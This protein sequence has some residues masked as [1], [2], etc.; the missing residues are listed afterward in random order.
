MEV[1][2]RMP[3]APR[4]QASSLLGVDAITGR[5]L[6]EEAA[7]APPAPPCID[8]EAASSRHVWCLGGLNQ[9]PDGGDLHT[10]FYNPATTRLAA[11]PMPDLPMPEKTQFAPQ[12]PVLMEALVL[13]GC[14]G[15]TCVCGSV[16]IAELLPAS[17][18]AL[19][20]TPR[21]IVRVR[22][23]LQRAGIV[24]A[25]PALAALTDVTMPCL[26]SG[27]GRD[28]DLFRALFA[29]AT[30]Y[31][32]TAAV[33]QARPAELVAY[34]NTVFV[35]QTL[36]N[37]HH[38]VA[39]DAMANYARAEGNRAYVQPRPLPP[40]SLRFDPVEGARMRGDAFCERELSDP[41]SNA[42]RRAELGCLMDI[43]GL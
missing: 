7:P 6:G 32:N 33:T 34:L 38:A 23:E 12:G 40:D 10:V 19:L 16:C 39:A 15:G 31:A 4:A 18:G 2:I 42:M 26:C 9:D 17:V 5:P 20:M 1:E 30:Q 29:F 24:V 8:P 25:T 11:P 28:P 36:D 13:D 3:F 27:L 43:P 22:R 35:R 41:R 14:G 37:I 21:N